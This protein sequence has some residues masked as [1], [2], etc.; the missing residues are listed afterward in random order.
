MKSKRPQIADH[1]TQTDE[2]IIRD[3]TDFELEQYELDQANMRAEAARYD[4]KVAA[5]ASAIAKLE[6]LGLTEDEARALLG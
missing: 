5:K 4:A 3:M 6:L 2:V 1:N